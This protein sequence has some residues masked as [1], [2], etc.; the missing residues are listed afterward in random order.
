MIGVGI[1]T[2][3]RP[4]RFREAF[5]AIQHPDIDRYYHVKD[6]GGDNY[7]NFKDLHQLTENRGV[8]VCKNIILQ[9]LLEQ[10]CD[11]IFLLEDDSLITNSD[12]WK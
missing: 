11:D 4:E 7:E 2:Y 1:V 3:N 6:G 5:D 8:G 12:V 10:G 9:N